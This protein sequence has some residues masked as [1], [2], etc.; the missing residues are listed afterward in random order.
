M[1]RQIPQNGEIFKHFKNKLYQV[2]GVAIHSET[3]EKL[4]V[5]QALY[6]GFK[7]YARP[8]SMF[9]SEVDHEKY[10]EIKQ[11]YR[12]T[13]VEL[14]EDGKETY[15][16]EI[17]ENISDSVKD[18][19]IATTPE[20]A[21]AYIETQNEEDEDEEE[22]SAIQ[23]REGIVVK[24][25]ISTDIEIRKTLQNA[26]ADKVKETPNVLGG[27]KTMPSTA[28]LEQKKESSSKDEPDMQDIPEGVNPKLIRFLDADSYEE[29][30][31][32]LVS[33]RD[34]ITDKLV[35]DIAVSMDVVVDEGP[36]WQRYDEL[37][38]ALKIRQK[39]EFANRLRR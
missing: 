13:R 38:N 7:M 1:K 4:V 2:V 34:E 36:L 37:K 31:N 29:R 19:S 6:G 33:L 23:G 10:P 39:Y 18:M 26:S 20:K 28:D 25:N 21:K 30:Y 17:T 8:I 32:I 15:L 16:E 22:N 35:D 24:E 9:L 12:F 27:E 5:Y 11:K 14:S 3:R